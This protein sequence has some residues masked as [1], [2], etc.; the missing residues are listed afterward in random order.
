MPEQ[1]CGLIP[2]NSPSLVPDLILVRF[3]VRKLSAQVSLLMTGHTQG[4]STDD[5][6]P[7]PFVQSDRAAKSRPV[8]NKESQRMPALAR[9]V[10]CRSN[11]RYGIRK[12]YSPRRMLP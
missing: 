5:S 7:A 8:T 1:V 10:N 6:P 3:A 12:K 11:R 2:L 4:P 9:S